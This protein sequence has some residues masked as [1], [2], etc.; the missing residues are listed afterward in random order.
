MADFDAIFKVYDIRGTVPDQIDAGA[1]PVGADIRLG[2]IE[3]MVRADPDPAPVSATGRRTRRDLLAECMAQVRSFV[4]TTALRPLQVVRGHRQRHRRLD[5]VGCSMFSKMGFV[6][7]S[8][9]DE[10]AYE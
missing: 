3:A 4:D 5:G 6:D 2:E 8:K 9:R 10:A 7:D 1:A